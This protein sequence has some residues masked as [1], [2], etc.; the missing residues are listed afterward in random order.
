MNL[1][2]GVH[3]GVGS[4]V[5]NGINGSV[6]NGVNG[7]ATNGVNGSVSNGVNG[8]V[9]N[10]VNGSASNGVNGSVPNGIN[11]YV[12]SG[13]KGSVNGHGLKIEDPSQN[14]AAHADSDG[15]NG[16][17]TN[18]TTDPACET[19]LAKLLIWSASDQDGAQKLSDAYKHYIDNQ[20]PV[21]DDL[22]YTLAVRRS[23]F[24]WRSFAVVDSNNG[25]PIMGTMSSAPV[26]ATA[27][28][29]GIAFVFTGQGAQYLGMGRQ[30][31]A[32]PIFRDNLAK[33]DDCLRRL[34]CQ[35]SLL[36]IIAGRS[37]VDI[38]RPEYSQPLTTCLQ[39]ALVDLLRSFN[40]VPSVVMGHSSG[41][42]AAAYAAGVLSQSS[43]VKIAY[44]RG[45]LS[46]QLASQVE[47]LT[48]MAVGLS[49]ENVIP[50]LDRLHKADGV[51]N[52]AVGCVNSPKSVTLTG[53]AHQLSKLDL[54]LKEDSIF[55]RKLRVRIA[56]HSRFMDPIA[57]DYSKAIE[58]LEMEQSSGFISMISSVTGDIVTAATLASADYWVRNLTSAVEF[59]AAFGRLL[60]RAN[61]KP[62][63]Q[64]GKT[65]TANPFAVS[66]VLEIGP[67]GAL[68]GPIRESLQAFD[69]AKKPGYISSLN[70]N[71]D[72][73]LAL[74]NAVGSLY[75]FGYP[76]NLLRANG[77][78]NSP[79]PAPADMPKYPF[80]HSQSHWREGHLSRNF[81]FREKAR[82]DLLGTRSLDWNPLMAQWRNVMRLDELPWL[83]DHTIGGEIVFPAAGMTVM[84]IEGL[85]EL[86]GKLA[87]LRG[88][89]IQNATFS[90]AISFPRGVDKIETQ[91]TL[92]RQSQSSDLSTWSQFRL[93]V[94]EN[95]S[96]IECCSGLI[97]AVIDEQDRDSITSSGPWTGG[98]L[99][100]WTARVNQACHGPEKDPYDVPAE[101]EV[102]YGPVF[103]NLE[104]MRLGDQG[105]AV[106][107][108]NTETCG[109]KTSG[110]LAP[111]FAVHPATLDGLAQPLLQALLAQEREVLP[112]MVPVRL[113]SLWVDCS[114]N[115]L[116]EGKLNVT[117]RCSFRGYR[118]G[119]AD[120]V[121]TAI[122]SSKPL[123]FL[124]GLE[125]TFISST[126]LAKPRRTVDHRLL[127][128]KLVWKPDID[129]MTHEQVLLHCIRG[130]P[131]LPADAVE[132][133]QSLMVAILCFVLDTIAFMDEN[134]G[135]KLSRHLQAYIGW[136]R[137]QQERLRN[138]KSLV[139]QQ[140]VQQVLDDSEA[141]EQLVS[142]IE[143]SAVDGF[144]FMQI[145]RNVTKML[146]GEI[147]PLAFM[148]HDGLADRYYEKMLANDHHAYPASQYIE[149]LS[150]KNPSMK[151]LEVGAGTG[152]Q[153]M[154]L[155]EAMSSDGVKKW[156]R[157]DYTDISP[158]FFSQARTKFH[159]YLDRM[160]FAV[161]D[162]S[163]YPISESFEAGTYDLVVASHV[164]H[165]TDNLRQSL[166]NIRKLLKPDGKLLLFETTR[167]EAIQVSFAFGLL[168]G[169][170]D[171]LEYEQRSLHSP[172]LTVEQWD[173]WLR[174][175][176]FSG[177][178]VEIPGQEI[179]LCR[180]S[181]IIVSSAASSVSSAMAKTSPQINLVVDDEVEAQRALAKLLESQLPE[182]LG[183]S[184]ETFTL[185]KLA[186]A[187]IPVSS[188]TIFLKEIDAV[189]LD[190]I[191]EADYRNLQSILV[192]AKDV[193]WATR[194][195]TLDRMEPRHH[196]ALGLGRTLMSEDSYRKFLLLSLDRYDRGAEQV[197]N[198]ICELSQ[199][200]I[201]LPVEG[202]EDCYV[203]GDGTLQICRVSENVD[204][205][206]KVAQAILP[207]QT[208]ECK[209]TAD[210]PVTLH[211]G[212]PGHFDT[213]EWKE[214]DDEGLRGAESL[215]P[216]EVVVQVRAIGLTFRDHLVASGQ[217]DESELGTECAGVVQ[218]AGDNSGLQVGDRVCL[219][220][221]STC[222]SVLRTAA[223]GVVTIPPH[224]SFAEAASLPTAL[225]LSYRALVDV[226]R[227]EKGE[228]VLIHRASSCV[229]QIAIQLAKQ[230]GA[231]V[232]VTAPSGASSELLQKQF[233]VPETD[234]FDTEDGSAV[235]K[236]YSRTDRAGVDVVIG[237]L[238]KDGH[239]ITFDFSACLAPFGR[240]VD[241]SLL[242]ASDS[243][244]SPLQFGN[245]AS[246]NISRASINM[247]DLLQRKPSLAHATFQRAAKMAFEP[248]FRTPQPLRAFGAS[249]VEA[250]FRN[251]NAPDVIGKSVVEMSP[252]MSVTVCI[253]LCSSTHA[254]LPAEC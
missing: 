194:A 240:L 190:G 145:G 207:R 34:G 205:D 47:G 120:V 19:T 171:P 84:A 62:R 11:G 44:Y 94:L 165:A 67:H 50:Y 184:C 92:S 195:G 32:F 3:N 125:T 114:S 90:H 196:L 208:I 12:T 127:C 15:A 251:F 212:A 122:D 16:R 144:F 197:A 224:M 52:V 159:K 249:E 128:T 140:S 71:Q 8:S 245:K 163:K 230:L 6:A 223:S 55:A 143:N 166:R 250:A 112:T 57:N 193:I 252:D 204:M 131:K 69:G 21:I 24:K 111:S 138:G 218:A 247:V 232:L 191:S 227:V 1:E 201:E 20:T 160:N 134:P 89:V 183:A 22:A 14:E 226:A 213:L 236:I 209:L 169:W 43:A 117:A 58:G 74:L 239:G 80:N 215:N 83:E 23:H 198:V 56:Y 155:L 36:D 234:I 41:E 59:E 116:H 172:C 200:V 187:D 31:V 170:W 40:I 137:Y 150:F 182:S 100:E 97:R 228:T 76:V 185:E 103:Q 188:V 129:T 105:E 133:Y 4:S 154:R 61:T 141:R 72:A 176:G 65:V 2:N 136:M 199:R 217:L 51:L 99:E 28:D 45:Q 242:R 68:Q 98:T 219:L 123:I 106:A 164:L 210:T 29:V 7:S 93:F 77:L 139:T 229:G 220:A 161:C 206:M 126:E 202:M 27:S 173:E 233:M 88:I 91:L 48:M 241:I 132:S 78:D 54:W 82:H 179:P 152:G 221:T 192:R 158:G 216:D 178:D 25:T 174:E 46:S 30:L 121:A 60:T 225:W 148:F 17:M 231:R 246:V 142:Q 130:R 73:C 151:I 238:A 95:G 39:L 186:Q 248:S 189:F 86:F 153:T 118:G 254:S 110:P 37:G 42:V 167:T 35:W 243:T 237:P 81:R 147:D 253:D 13:I 5:T 108:V 87:S 75:S 149:L 135:T 53:E 10:G 49:K 113:A 177:V 168:K 115:A 244:P 26:K 203:A 101:I 146:R 175:A 124:E 222:R 96:Y 18:G 9:S 102:R 66:H 156:A 162:I 107:Q 235:S 104:H 85:R 214:S 109:L 181:S 211:L 119:S 157:Y 33:S 70:R 79:R 63:K 180:D 64:L 38:D